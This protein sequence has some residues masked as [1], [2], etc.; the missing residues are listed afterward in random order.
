M[1][2][3]RLNE[4]MSVVTIRELAF[5]ANLPKFVRGLEE[6]LA[7]ATEEQLLLAR[8]KVSALVDAASGTSD[9]FDVMYVLLPI[10]LQLHN[11]FGWT[12][13]EQFLGKT[14]DEQKAWVVKMSPTAKE[15]LWQEIGKEYRKK[16][17]EL[18]ALLALEDKMNAELERL[19]K[20][21]LLL[22]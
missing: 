8:D 11:R 1:A 16:D 19:W 17:E 18:R 13:A 22:C 20:A 3:F 7:E 12:T 14:E 15:A 4:L 21:E 9:A 6:D 5:F 10:N 2:L